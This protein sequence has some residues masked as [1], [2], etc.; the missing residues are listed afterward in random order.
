MEPSKE[1][2]SVRIARLNSLLLGRVGTGNVLAKKHRL[3]REGLMDALI[4]LYDECNNDTLKKDR[5]IALFVEKYRSL[6]SELRCLRVNISDFE[7][8][9]VIGRGH[10]GEVQVVREKQTGDVYAMKTLRKSDTLSQQAAAF[11]EEERDIM[12]H[13]SS[14]WITTLQYAFQDMHNLYLVMEFHP[15]GDLLALLDRFDG[16]LEEDTA[17]FYLA[18]LVLA[19]RSL[20]MM[21]YVHRDIKPDNILIDRCGHL[22]LAD[23]GSAAKLT[24][25]GVVTSQMPVG[26]PEYIAPEVL[27]SM[28]ASLGNN[29]RKIQSAYGVECDYWSLGIVAYEMVM[30]ITPFSGNQLTATYYN[31]MNHKSS[32]QFSEEYDASQSFRDLVKGLLDDATSRLGHEQLMKH[33]FFSSID[34]NTLREAV[35]PFVPIVNGVDDTSNFVEFEHEPPT[36]SIENFKTKKGFCGNNLPFLG[37]TYVQDEMTSTRT[38][39]TSMS[40]KKK[41]DDLN[42]SLLNQ[43]KE[44]ENLQRK[45]HQLESD[46][47]I[48]EVETLE[49]KLEQQT[50]KY[51]LLTVDKEELERQ[52]EKLKNER[53]SLLRTLDETR[54]EHK[55]VETKAVQLLRDSKAK[56]EKKHKLE[57]ENLEKQIEKQTQR[58]TELCTINNTLSSK[59]ERQEEDL[60][61]AVSEIEMLQAMVQENQDKMAKARE[62]NRRSVVG[63]E[64]TLERIAADNQSQLAALQSQLADETKLCSEL[65]NRLR[66]LE[67]SVAQKEAELSSLKERETTQTAALTVQLETCQHQCSELQQRVEFLEEQNETAV[68]NMEAS[69]KALVCELEDKLRREKQECKELRTRLVNLEGELSESL[70]SQESTV[71]AREVEREAH[72]TMLEA[73]L[74]QAA[75]DKMKL[76]HRLQE[77]KTKEEEDNRKVETLEGLLQRLEQGLARLE[78]ENLKLKA[79]TIS[80]DSNK[81]SNIRLE[82]LEQQKLILLAQVEKLELQVEKLRE[83][84][85]LD[86][87]AAKIAQEQLW[88]KEKEL[89]DTKIDLRIAQREAKTAEE[90]LKLLQEEKQ[91]WGEKLQTEK[92]VSAEQLQ[93]EREKLDKL[94]Q[95]VLSLNSELSDLKQREEAA[96]KQVDVEKALLAQKKSELESSKT[97]AQTLQHELSMFQ[98]QSKVFEDQVAVMQ[99]ETKRLNDVINHLQADRINLESELE[100]QKKKIE[101]LELNNNVLKELCTMQDVQL[102]EFEKLTKTYKDKEVV[103]AKEKKELKSQLES[104]QSQLQMASKATNEEKSLRIRAETRIQALEAELQVKSDDLTVLQNQLEDYRSLV[105]DR[106]K[107]VTELEDRCCTTELDWRNTCRQLQA[108]KDE[109]N[110]LKEEITQQL[111]QIHSV[112]ESNFKLNRDLEDAIDQIRQLKMEY[113]ALET[114]LAEMEIHYKHREYKSDSTIQQQT[115]LIDYLQKRVEDVGKKKKTL[116]DK[117][118]G[119]RQKENV[120]LLANAPPY[121][122]KELPSQQHLQASKMK[123]FADREIRQT[124]WKDADSGKT[125]AVTAM[126]PTTPLSKKALTHLVQSP[127]SQT[128]GSFA[129]QP[130]LLRMHY[131]IP[132]RFEQK[133]CMRTIKCAA[134]LDSIQFGHYSSVCQ[135]CN[136]SSHPKC[137][138]V[139]PST[140]GIPSGFARHFSQ[141]WKR[142][143]MDDDSSLKNDGADTKPDPCRMEG[144]VKIPKRGRSCWERKYLRLEGSEL[145]IFDHEP[146]DETMCPTSTFLVCRPEG[147]TSILSSVPY[148]EV[149]STAKSDLPFILKVEV[150]PRTT[151]WPGSSLLIMTLGL[152]DKQ[153]WVSALEAVVQRYNSNRKDVDGQPSRYQGTTLLHID[154]TEGLDLN[155][156]LQLSPGIMLLGAEEG[157]F[158]FRLQE[159]N[160]KPVKIHGITHVHQLSMLPLLNCLI[161]LA[162]EQRT[163]MQCDLRQVRS[164]AEA[165]ECVKPSIVAT[166][167]LQDNEPSRLGCCLLFAASTTKDEK[168]HARTILCAATE[169]RIMLL[170]WNV[171]KS[172]F[173]QTKVLDI[174]ESCSCIHFARHSII[175]GCNKFFE[176][177]IN[178]FSMEEFLDPSDKSLAHAV[179]GAQQLHSYPVAILDVTKSRTEEPEYLLCF[180]AFGV[181][182]DKFGQRTRL[183]DIKWSHLPL[184]FAYRK[185]Y[186][187][188][189]H[190]TSVE[191]MKL[192]DSSF[193][194]CQDDSSSTV[195]YPDQTFI[196]LNN[197]RY[198]GPAEGQGPAIYVG[199]CTQSSVEM[200]LIEGTLACKEEISFSSTRDSVSEGRRSDLKRTWIH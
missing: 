139:L 17:R 191:V 126:V 165:A 15:G 93:A 137:S 186:L 27:E 109:C 149:V 26:T 8:K 36:L 187:F 192:S 195:N 134:C 102:D 110:A 152:S 143:Q 12:A 155:C 13:A 179:F 32:L 24:A 176:I 91:K 161:V 39:K 14:P 40:P 104:M 68:K 46:E 84:S 168:D 151:C 158:S 170:R 1:P 28:E 113:A 21:G 130:S 2:I 63:V 70:M 121:K 33:T 62:L 82:E 22:K 89:S 127:G 50:H 118:F 87:Q 181:F 42:E 95:Q 10:F 183:D 198:L 38:E 74:K 79:Q 25:A 172:T 184:S 90:Q 194:R 148:S 164:S 41:N 35:P 80:E 101:S 56:W 124:I 64:S 57:L 73:E 147:T 180:S 141:S 200:L 145:Q 106:T 136:I 120:S 140:C 129:R 75:A 72:V 107:E 18:E 9:K 43:K 117:L 88:K 166:P 188:I 98:K 83:A 159:K 160:A 146:T 67:G 37:F 69:N 61:S 182:V 167:L 48:R 6:V 125:P 114:S 53:L 190:F 111:T 20:H 81:D 54:K 71:A 105:E 44:I 169:K 174:E 52:C 65:Q 3:G 11:Y 30:G 29:K 99:V 94:H 49:K 4:V 116:T 59:V 100:E 92:N 177:D 103:H 122:S 199:H 58:I 60:K 86:R 142:S 163:L 128:P 193:T 189:V 51:E 150:S 175:V 154:R 178:D 19:I 34:W 76:Q 135:E 78:E 45:I 123:S 108:S 162:G 196:E 55:M 131:N 115:K 173:Q 96:K 85:V 156:C 133:V 138:L 185:P 31:I 66:E 77:A 157:L 5:N 132:H 119:S 112:K 23:F 171:S 7:V 197:P 16:L 144:Y 153:S 47:K 97:S